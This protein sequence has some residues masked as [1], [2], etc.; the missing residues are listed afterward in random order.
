LKTLLFLQKLPAT[1]NLNSLSP[2]FACLP[3]TFFHFLS[4]R[5]SRLCLSPL[6]M[7]IRELITDPTLRFLVSLFFIVLLLAQLVSQCKGK[8]KKHQSEFFWVG[9]GR[10]EFEIS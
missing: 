9:F 1:K 7:P 4:F 8:S 6:T 5:I 2:V 3:Q 10:V